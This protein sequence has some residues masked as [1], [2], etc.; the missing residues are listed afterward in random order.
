MRPFSP[1]SYSISYRRVKSHDKHLRNSHETSC[2][3]RF[4]FL[5]DGQT[6]FLSTEE[7]F[8]SQGTLNFFGNATV[9]ADQRLLFEFRVVPT[10][11]EHSKL[12]VWNE[13]ALVRNQE[14]AVVTLDGDSFF[15]RKFA[16]VDFK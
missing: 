12:L 5:V 10:G 1:L 4:E 6:Q 15:A 2:G 7:R 13:Q 8:L 16:T 9:V 3:P 14:I 11:C